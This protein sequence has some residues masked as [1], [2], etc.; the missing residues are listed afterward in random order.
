MNQEVTSTTGISN[1]DSSLKR[2]EKRAKWVS[3]LF[4][5]PAVTLMFVILLVPIFVAAGLSFTD[6][7]LGNP[8]FKWLGGKN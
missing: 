1:Q 2:A 7:S 6:Y 5:F 8:D 3:Y 4:C